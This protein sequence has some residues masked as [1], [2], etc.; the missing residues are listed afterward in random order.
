MVWLL[1]HWR[2]HH[3]SHTFLFLQL[4]IPAWQMLEPVR[5]GNIL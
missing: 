5:W 1:C 2:I 3:H 4:V